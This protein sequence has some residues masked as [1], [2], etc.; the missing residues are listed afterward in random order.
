VIRDRR[1]FRCPLPV[2]RP[3]HNERST[4]AR[5]AV[6]RNAIPEEDW[7]ALI[8]RAE[9]EGVRALARDLG[10]SREAVRSALRA[11]GRADLLAD[12]ARRRLLEATAPP[13]PAPP[14]KIPLER[15]A[16]VRRLCE[17]HTQAEV[18]AMFGV[19]QDTIWRIVHGRRH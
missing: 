12:L 17:R 15:H 4:T 14:R 5:Y 13:P 18:A 8:E 7:P 16:E 11:A 9:R 6:P 19:S 10:V 2:A 3:E 1:P